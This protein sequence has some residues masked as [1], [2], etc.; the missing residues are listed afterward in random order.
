MLN[1]IRGAFR[2]KTSVEDNLKYYIGLSEGI[3]ALG[4]FS[5]I[6][7]RK[8]DI[9]HHFQGKGLSP[10]R[11]IDPSFWEQLKDFFQEKWVEALFALFIL[12]WFFL[13]RVAV[14]AEMDVLVKLYSRINPPHDW[15]RTVG[16]RMI[17]LL[18]LGLTLA[19][20]GLA[21]TMD[22]LELF[23]IIMLLLNVQDAY[24]NN[25][26]RKNL[27]RHF[28]DKKYTPHATDLHAPF[29][30][31]RREIALDYWVWRPQL[32]RIGLMMI[33][34]I[35]AF[36]SVISEQAFGIAI[37]DKLPY[38]IIMVVIFANEVTMGQWRIARDIRLE[39]VETQQEEHEREMNAEVMQGEKPKDE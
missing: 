5:F 36:L 16:R 35:I 4:L 6:F 12:L 32:E 30:L 33:G 2:K 17:P 29:I 23:C 26:L 18:S 38:F 11:V 7:H 34:V 37:W 15:E 13:Y 14:K 27:L 22:R 8:L 24:G 28:Y 3:I 9:E 39:E 1:I 10:M 25:L 20:L 19:F 21:L 31:A